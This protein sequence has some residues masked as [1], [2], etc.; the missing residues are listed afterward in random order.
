MRNKSVGALIKVVAK[1]VRMSTR[2]MIA[3]DFLGAVGSA[4]IDTYR[5]NYDVKL[6]GRKWF[7]P[8]YRPYASTFEVKKGQFI[9]VREN[10]YTVDIDGTF[11]G[12]I[13]TFTSM[14]QDW[15]EKRHYFLHIPSNRLRGRMS[16]VIKQL[17]QA[18][19]QQNYG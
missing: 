6:L 3:A 4:Q 19:K 18:R 8:L 9:T 1:L 15:K 2:D 11:G 5:A 16:A 7:A 10:K 14:L 13:L 17:I 12:E